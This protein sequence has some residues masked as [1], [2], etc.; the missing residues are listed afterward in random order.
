MAAII[1]MS[2][3]TLFIRPSLLSWVVSYISSISPYG[4]FDGFSAALQSHEYYKHYRYYR[5]V[6]YM[7]APSH[8]QVRNVAP[9]VLERK[10]HL[11]CYR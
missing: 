4:S 9:L 1:A 6:E 8:C 5:L 2:T 3:T 7:L 11:T 10:R